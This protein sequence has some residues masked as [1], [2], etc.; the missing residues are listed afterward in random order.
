M[1]LAVDIG[2]TSIALGVFENEKI[3][4]KSKITAVK[5]K[6]SD[7]YA[8]LIS[9][10]FKINSISAKDITGAVL[11]SVVPGLSFVICDALEKLS[12]TALVLG[13]GVK[14]GLDIRTQS[15]ESVGSDIV[16]EAVGA[17]CR[18]EAPLAVID[19]GTATTISVI[20]EKR[21]LCGCVIAP[22]VKL[23]G[24]ALSSACA[25]LP[26]V[27]LSKNP[28]FLGTN[29]AESINSGLVWG[30]AL[31]LDGFVDKIK[32]DTG[33]EKNLTVVATGGLCD[34]VVPL[35]TNKIEIEDDLTLIGLLKIYQLNN[36]KK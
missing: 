13:A 28:K 23:S 3:V 17:L 4:F 6:S 29:T 31:M 25:L 14:T 34:L 1:I 8:V 10:I 26:D 36:K 21:E 27:S 32:A 15:P 24:D 20:G 16:A 33:F 9:D 19:L 22:G 12:I 2:N 5:T 35:C 30:T 11:L 18:F 7:E